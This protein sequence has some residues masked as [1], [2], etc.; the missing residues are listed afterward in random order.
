MPHLPD[1]EVQANLAPG[2]FLGEGAWTPPQEGIAPG[3][4][5]DTRRRLRTGAEV[6]QEMGSGTMIR[7]A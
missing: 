6:E 2:L 1:G 7:I 3:L 4:P 5:G